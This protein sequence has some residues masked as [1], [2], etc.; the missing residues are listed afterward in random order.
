MTDAEM[1]DM[2]DRLTEQVDRWAN[3]Y[4][5]PPDF[6]LSSDRELTCTDP[7][8]RVQ[9]TMKDFAVASIHI[10]DT[11]HAGS[12]PSL[13]EIEQAVRAAVNA[14]LSVYWSA[15]LDDAKAHRT[16][17]GEIA[18]GLEKL[19]VEFRGAYANAVARLE[20]HDE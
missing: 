16:P 6:E 11:W 18:A 13:M 1:P 19:S 9:V 20:S 7:A 14:T 10:D 4:P 5:E 8:G 15:E 2:F 12:L 3:E 17:M